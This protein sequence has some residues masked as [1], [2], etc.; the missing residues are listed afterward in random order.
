MMGSVLD[1]ALDRTYELVLWVILLHLGMV[2]VAI[3]LIVVVR[4]VLTD[5]LRSV[6]V[7]EGKRPF[8]QQEGSLGSFLV[9]SPWMRSS[10]G[11]S[12]ILAFCGLTLAYAFSLM[13]EY[14]WAAM[15]SS[16]FKDI[17]LVIAW[18]AAFLCVV[19]GLPVIVTYGKLLFGEK[20]D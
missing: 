3:P 9:K 2:P 5:A 8:D 6:G 1:I 7:S 12:K 17:F 18:I 10:Y 19:R 14:S 4:T 15:N 13:P 20:S 16:L 11:F